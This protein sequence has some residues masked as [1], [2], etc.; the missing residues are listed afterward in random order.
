MSL[1]LDFGNEEKEFSTEDEKSEA[2]NR[3]GKFNENDQYFDSEA[4]AEPPHLPDWD[5]P[6]A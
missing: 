2:L 3:A 5:D 1:L 4:W 6:G